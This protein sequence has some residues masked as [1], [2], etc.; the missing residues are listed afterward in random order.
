MNSTISM[1][2]ILRDLTPLNRAVCSLDYDRAV[3]YLNEILPFRT[4]SVQESKQHNGWV[5]PPSWDVLEARIEK[6]G[7]TIYDGTTHPL[8]V[9]ALSSNFEGIGEPRRAYAST[10][11]TII[12]IPTRSRFTTGSSSEAGAATGDS[13]CRSGFM[14][15]SARAITR[16]L[17]RTTEAPGEMKILE[18]THSGSLGFT[19]ALAGNLD[20][21]GV[22]ND[23]LAG[24]VVGLEVLRRLQGRSTKFSYSLVLSP[25]I[26]GSELYLAGLSTTERGRHS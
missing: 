11:T 25:G 13:A 4:I 14:I 10:C 17:I 18:Y 1:M 24:C 20:H 9:I 22:A 7:Q 6:N 23:G 26:I 15:N 21:A 16:V 2:E 3:K 8:G 5:V 19:I 12:A